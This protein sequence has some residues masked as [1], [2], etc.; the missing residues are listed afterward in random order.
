MSLVSNPN[1]AATTS[2][3]KKNKRV[4]N[5]R[6]RE[7]KDKFDKWGREHD[8]YTYHISKQSRL[9]WV[10]EYAVYEVWM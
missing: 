9:R 5:M 4:E 7:K 6:E 3:W 8:I 10:C 1:I 2:D